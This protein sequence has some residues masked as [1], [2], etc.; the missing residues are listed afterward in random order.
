MPKGASDKPRS[1]T[2]QW[3]DKPGS[4]DQLCDAVAQGG[5]LWAFTQ[6]HGLSYSS[7]AD[8]IASDDERRAKYARAREAR[9]DKLADE[10][11]SISD[12]LEVAAQHDGENVRLALDATAVARN[13]LRVDA[14]KWVAAKLKPRVY[15]DRTTVAGDAEAPLQHEIKGNVTLTPSDAYFQLLRGGK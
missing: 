2:L 10:I 7:V 4:I 11:V 15:G 6:E 3:R 12:E 14:R 13:R 8:W 5:N 1:P 9:A